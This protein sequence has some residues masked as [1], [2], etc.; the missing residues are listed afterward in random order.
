MRSTGCYR[1][2]ATSALRVQARNGFFGVRR[3]F[4]IAAPPG[5]DGQR[6]TTDIDA[7]FANTDARME[8]GGDHLPASTTVEVRGLS[9]P[10]FLIEVEVMA[11]MPER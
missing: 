9:R 5:K 11:V 10:D 4:T 3:E 6:F 2:V 8:C 1:Y 7:W